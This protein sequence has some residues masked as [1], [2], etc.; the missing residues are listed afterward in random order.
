MRRK[1]FLF[2]ACNIKPV[3]FLEFYKNENGYKAINISMKNTA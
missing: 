1:F 3:S 2:K